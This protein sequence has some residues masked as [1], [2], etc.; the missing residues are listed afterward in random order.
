MVIGWSYFV[1]SSG[2]PAS[3]NSCTR[4]F[5]REVTRSEACIG[6]PPDISGISGTVTGPSH[7]PARLFMVAKDFCAS[8]GTGATEDFCRSDCAKATVESDIR[9]T[10][11]TKRR[12]FMFHSPLEVHF[13]SSLL[14]VQGS[15]AS[16]SSDEPEQYCYS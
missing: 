14:S 4:T 5:P 10:D 16:I 11:S 2:V 13:F 7:S 8:G 15:L 3:W 1:A 6:L 12:D 9:T